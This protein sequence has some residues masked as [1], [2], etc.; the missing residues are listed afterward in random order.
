V[1]DLKA[2]KEVIALCRLELGNPDT[3]G[4]EGDVDD[5]SQDS[6]VLRLLAARLKKAGAGGGSSGL[7]ETA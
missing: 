6:D 3:Q 2:T 5:P 4:L 7:D 1:V